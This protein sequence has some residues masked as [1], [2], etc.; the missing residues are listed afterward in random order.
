MKVRQFVPAA[1]LLLAASSSALASGDLFTGSIQWS[2]T[3]PSP[4]FATANWDDTETQLSWRIT[5]D[6]TDA[7][8]WY[9]EYTWQTGTGSDGKTGKGLSHLVIEVSAGSVHGDFDDIRAEDP[10]TYGPADSS[11]PGIP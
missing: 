9:Y 5:Y 3:A 1:G 10:K 6:S 4:I 2:S 8:P 11:N 7:F